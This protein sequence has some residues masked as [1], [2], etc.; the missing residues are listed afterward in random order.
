MSKSTVDSIMN[1][2]KFDRRKFL[3]LM[4]AMPM[5]SVAPSL[6]AKTTG[7][8]VQ[9]EGKILVM[10]ELK[11]G[12]DALNTLVPYEDP[13]YYRLRPKIALKENQVLKLGNGF[14]M[15]PVMKSLLPEWQSGDM[16]WVQGIGYPDPNRSHF[17]S[18]E[19][20]ESASNSNQYLDDGWIAQLYGKASSKNIQGV[21]IGSDVGPLSGENFN[22]LLMQ[23][24]KS[25]IALTKRLKSVQ[26]QTRNSALSHVLGVQNNVHSNAQL[27]T[28][29]LKNASSSSVRFPKNKFGRQLETTSQIILSGLDVPVFKVEIGSFDTHQGQ[30]KK[31]AKLLTQL[32]EGLSAFSNSMKKAGLWDDV[33]IV[34][35]SEFG[36]RVK[37][38][39][40]GGTDHGTAAAHFALGGRVN[41]GVQNGLI[42]KTPS[43]S[44]LDNNDLRFTTDFRTYYH[45]I[46]SQWLGVDSNWSRYGSL[47]MIES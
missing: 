22:A 13:N 30:Q 37:E 21:S 3:Q 36:R 31:Q 5:L 15:N 19:I 6:L 34:T 8:S 32:S 20:W 28:E 43:L 17:R 23:D 40:S 33:L 45:T 18:I 27:V 26:A 38:N 10:V 42:G 35:Y 4:T 41:G 47:P 1:S 16:A 9:T 14:G 46:A 24:K 44:Q 12:N 25:F 11:G 39:A 7:S 29:R 2:A